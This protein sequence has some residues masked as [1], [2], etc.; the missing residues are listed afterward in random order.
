MINAAVYA[1]YSSDNQ[2]DES[3]DAQL[4]AAYEYCKKKEY[5]IVHEYIDRVQTATN[6]NRPEYQAMMADAKKKMFDVIVFHKIDRNARNEFDYYYHKTQLK[7]YNIRYE[8]VA[9][10][11]DDS[12]EGQMME[13][14]MVSF[15]AYYSRN[16]AG[17]VKKGHRENAHQ[18]LW[19]GGTPPLGYDVVDRKLKINEQEADAVRLAFRMRAEGKTF[20]A[21]IKALN[22]A[23]HLTK[24]KNKFTPNSISDLLSNEKYIG[25]YVFG[26][27]TGGRSGPRNSHMNNPDAIRY[28]N[29][30][31]AIIDRATW[32]MV[33]DKYAKRLKQSN[34]I[35][36]YLL[37]GLIS[38]ECGAP[39]CGGRV[40]NQKGI[41]Y[42]YY[43][44]N[45]K[46]CKVGR[47]KRETV[48]EYVVECL[49]EHLND[50]V[51]RK[52]LAQNIED[53]ANTYSQI[54]TSHIAGIKKEIAALDRKAAKLL[55]AIETMG[56]SSAIADRLK[57]ID[58]QKEALNKKVQRA[59]AAAASLVGRDQIEA[60]IDDCAF[61]LKDNKNNPDKVR[62]VL[63]LFVDSITVK[64][65]TVDVV[66]KFAPNWWRRGESNP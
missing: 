53:H 48:E 52:A 25:T 18:H 56:I 55:D 7:K 16:L 6:D 17:E 4:R 8:Y 44:C 47:I 21:I 45:D 41:L 30:I 36:T 19:N 38:C 46:K 2:R 59:S 20:S 24:K 65:T 13:G 22:E 10:N 23:G 58:K 29:A 39:M 49:L 9:Q 64:Q 32:E 31:P 3:I 43:R 14:I 26:K 57:E 34:Q 11:I 33:R 5:R 28:E 61:I 66:Y 50:S 60:V 63:E 40:R 12:P 1:R 37:S 54:Y 15:A 42:V 35:E 51:K 62:A 27:V